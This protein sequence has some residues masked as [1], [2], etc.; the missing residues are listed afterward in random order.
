MRAAAFMIRSIR[1]DSRMI[2]HHLMRAGVAVLILCLFVVQADV[3]P[4]Q[5]GA[6]GRFAS[7]VLYCAYFFLSLLLWI[8]L[9]YI[10]SVLFC[11][12]S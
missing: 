2:G 7:Q 6:G 9:S 4:I 1:Q 8:K 12:A 3:S 5:V 11:Q 10:Q